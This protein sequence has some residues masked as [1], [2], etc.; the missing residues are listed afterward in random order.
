[1]DIDRHSQSLGPRQDRFERRI[2]K[3]AT[4]RRTIY[5]EPVEAE[6]LDRPF[7]SSAAA[8]GECIGKCAKPRNRP[9]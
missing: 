8:S 2:I 1:M 6:I 7:S 4:V 5:Q 3:E 9:G